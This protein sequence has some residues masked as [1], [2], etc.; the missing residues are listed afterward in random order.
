MAEEEVEPGRLSVKPFTLESEDKPDGIGSFSVD[1]GGPDDGGDASRRDHRHRRVPRVETSSGRLRSADRCDCER[2][3]RAVCLAGTVRVGPVA[4]GSPAGGR[5]P[6]V[7]EPGPGGAG[8]RAPADTRGGP[9]V[10]ARAMA[11]A[12]LRAET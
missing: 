4:S 8:E 3:G 5:P 1:E 6:D 12:A 7:P 10:A 11:T 9:W 2:V